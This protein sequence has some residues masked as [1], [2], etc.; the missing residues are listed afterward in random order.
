MSDMPDARRRRIIRIRWIVSASAVLLTTVVVLAVGGF[1]ER[2]TRRTLTRELQTRVL[3]ESRN[4][5]MTSAG[6]LLSDFP[7]LTLA[8]ILNDM[9][10]GQ[11]E[12][13]FAL[14]TDLDGV[15]RGHAD[16]RRIGENYTLLPSLEPTTDVAGLRA[17]E[18][19]LGDDG[20]IVSTCPV[21]HPGAGTIGTA[22]VAIERQYID[23]IIGDARR[24]QVVLVFALLAGGIVVTTVF[25]S[26][27]LRPVD[28]LREG[29]ERIGRGDLETPVTVRDRTEF[30][31]LATTM[32]EMSRKLRIAQD[33][34][35]EKERLA[36]EVELARE[37][38]A[39]LLPSERLE[40]GSFVIDGAQ[41]SAAEVGGDYYD[42]FSLSD[43]RIG[44]VIADVAG[45]GLGGCLVTS[46]LSALLRAFRDTETSPSGLIVRVENTLKDSLRPG[47]FITMFYGILDPTTGTFIFSSAGHSPLL[48][49]RATGAIE[50]YKTGGI[51]VGAVRSGV[52]ARMLK[53]QRVILGANDFAVQFTDGINEAFDTAGKT[54]FGFKR[55]EQAVVRSARHGSRAVID[56]IRADLKTWTGD[57]PPFD[58]ETLLVIGAPAVQ[59]KRRPTSSF[60]APDPLAV[61]EKA[62]ESGERLT[63]RADVT[64]LDRVQGWVQRCQGMQRL[65]PRSVFVL[66]TALYEV[67]ANVVEHGYGSDRDRFFDLWW[68]P[69]FG[70]D[71]PDG[72]GLF[73]LR[74]DGTPF[75][76]DEDAFVDFGDPSVRRRGRGI[77][78]EIIREAMSLI[79]YNPGTTAGNVTILGFDPAKIRNEE[80]VSHVS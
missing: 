45:K 63:L 34:H 58:D 21:Q 28:A 38:Q 51:P 31:L 19:V 79:S 70:T 62:R 13:A 77:G 74:D 33:E 46:M 55:I 43:G 48:V 47:T 80:E 71:S 40:A 69:S 59:A 65:P 17:E 11:P 10:V 78:L 36:R 67:C 15:I 24:Q 44:T 75:A 68:M 30:G 39:S 7:E 1:S 37:I 25:L 16:P 52:L 4:L 9:S 27:L 14:V 23:G 29:L 35:V 26:A 50:W 72:S 76:P 22:V 66:E 32:N 42:V 12:L 60:V 64:Q 73:V 61:I 54:Q 53:D 57:Q 49:C 8:P 6:A 2:N 20:L 41:R 5:A 3:L 56:A 18:T